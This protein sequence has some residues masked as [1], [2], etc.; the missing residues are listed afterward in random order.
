VLDEGPL[1]VAAGADV[2]RRCTISLASGAAVA[3][4]ETVV[5]GRDGEPPGT[6]DGTLRVTLDGRPLLYDGLRFSAVGAHGDA[7]VA[8][9]PGHRVLAT[10][11]LLGVRPVSE[12]GVL[13]LEGP[14]GLRRASG[15]S[16]A[17][18]DAAVAV[19]WTA[20]SRPSV[21]LT[22]RQPASW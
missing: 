16:L 10:V 5:L 7:H 11:S 4:R 21:I 8:L 22:P 19:L 2:R 13:E 3:L 9:P 12:P 1:I 17:D 15:A 14:G 6:L 20:W 18:V